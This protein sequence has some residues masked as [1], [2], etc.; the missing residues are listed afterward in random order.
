MNQDETF[1]LCNVDPDDVSEVLAKIE[2]SLGFTFGRDDFKEVQTFGEMCD[3]VIAKTNCEHKDDC[4]SQQAFYKL[5][6]AIAETTLIEARQITL[7]TDA[8]ELFPKPQ[9]RKNVRAVEKKLG[10]KLNLLRP[11]HLIS[12]IFVLELLAS[13]VW[14]FIN[15]QIGLAGIAFY[16][17]GNAVAK[18]FASEMDSQRFKQLVQKITRQHYRQVRRNAATI[19]RKEVLEQITMLFAEDL[20]LEKSAL[21][22]SATFN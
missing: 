6:N 15:W 7:N 9:R 18:K 11:R 13:I 3:V 5:R 2:K 4:T 22:K 8:Q 16:I 12:G 19:N 20:G 14:L 10:F 1:K 17:V 21:S